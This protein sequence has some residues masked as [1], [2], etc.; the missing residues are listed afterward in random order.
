[1]TAHAPCSQGTQLWL[2]DPSRR[3][4]GPGRA[5]IC[6]S[7]RGR[8]TSPLLL[9]GSS[10]RGLL[11]DLLLGI[12]SGGRV[13]LRQ[14]REAHLLCGFFWKRCIL[15]ASI[16][17]VLKNLFLFYLPLESISHGGAECQTGEAYT[18]PPA[19]VLCSE[20]AWMKSGKRKGLESGQFC[21]GYSWLNRRST[22]S[23]ALHTE[24]R[25]RESHY[26]RTPDLQRRPYRQAH[27]I[28]GGVPWLGISHH[29]EG[30]S[31]SEQ[32]DAKTPRLFGCP[33]LGAQASSPPSC[34]AA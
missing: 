17:S 27:F 2:T 33:L 12:F 20:K 31:V 10:G 21:W 26:A 5:R 7:H 6:Q 13:T 24:G 14:R 25:G 9:C 11:R 32:G 29:T 23:S 16:T 3:S 1:M 8:Q 18:D 28:H 34:S 22:H 4:G 30:S 19:R 15:A